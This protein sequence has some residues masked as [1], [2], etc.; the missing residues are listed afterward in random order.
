MSSDN[1][2]I[3][4]MWWFMKR[5]KTRAYWVHPYIKR[6]FNGRAFIVATELSHDDRKFQLFYRISKESFAEI[7]RVV[8]PAISK[9]TNRG[10]YIEV[11]EAVN[12]TL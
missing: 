7:V 6:H 11:E 2:D 8:G 9:D 12:N 10:K 4:A 3:I 5:R 1:E